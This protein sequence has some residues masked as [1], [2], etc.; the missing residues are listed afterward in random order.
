MAD[1]GVIDSILG[2]LDG[3][4]PS[5]RAAASFILRNRATAAQLDAQDLAHEAGV[6]PSTITRLVRD[7]G[8]DSYAHMRIDLARQ[9]MREE[10]AEG[11]PSSIRMD[12]V[13]GSL[14]Y[15]AANKV[16]E[17]RACA[18]ML[19]AEAIER[20]VRLME[21][22]GLIVFAGIGT[23]MSY[24]Q[25]CAFKFTQFGIR[26]VALS[27]T[28]ATS[29]LAL[30]LGPDD[31]VVFVSNSGDS[32]RLERVMSV[33]ESRGTPT[34][35]L[36]GN[37]RSSLGRHAS[38]LIAYPLYDNL[39]AEDYMFSLSSMNIVMESLL[40]LLLHD[41]EDAEERLAQYR[42]YFR[43]ERR[44]MHFPYDGEAEAPAD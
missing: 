12:D 34:I 35:V 18:R 27:N 13:A 10:A 14:A 43:F 39:F 42:D 11:D 40:L 36:T 30:T 22:S 41:A 26:A 25:I 24:A 16:E 37:P 38:V 33:C 20:A 44:N 9:E 4:S 21:R 2:E 15:I 3:L 5:E 32:N 1:R 8:Y 19:D 29:T 28:D 31:C 17:L 23:G 7:L 6:S